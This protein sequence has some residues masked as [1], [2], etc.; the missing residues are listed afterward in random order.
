MPS[1]E[2]ENMDCRQRFIEEYLRERKATLQKEWLTTKSWIK[3]LKKHTRTEEM[4]RLIVVD[5]KFNEEWLDRIKE[6]FS[7]QDSTPRYIEKLLLDMDTNLKKQN[8]RS[9]FLLL[10]GALITATFKLFG[11]DFSIVL[12]LFGFLIAGER[13]IVDETVGALEELKLLVKYAQKE[14]ME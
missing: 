2:G 10:Y 13:L 7:E 5:S 1:S 4:I 9:F 12:V 14:Y 3:R 6:L 8:N 11:L